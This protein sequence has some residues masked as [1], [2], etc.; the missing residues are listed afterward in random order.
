MIILLGRRSRT[1]KSDYVVL[2]IYHLKEI[3]MGLFDR[4]SMGI[5]I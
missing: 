3:R 2:N 5:H 4:S 1:D